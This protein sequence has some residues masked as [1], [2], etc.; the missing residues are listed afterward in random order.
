MPKAN[1]LVVD[2]EI[3]VAKVVSSRLEKAGFGVSAASNGKNALEAV[4][5]SLPDLILLDIMMPGM[6]GYEVAD[7]LRKDSRT[8]L[9]PII[10]LTAKAATQ[11]KIKALKKPANGREPIVLVSM[12]YL[13]RY[14]PFRRH[15]ST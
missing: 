9:V 13:R 6:D 15:L 1:I 12:T 7:K 14:W 8:S 10:M 3:D 11:D 2:D 4:K 5:K